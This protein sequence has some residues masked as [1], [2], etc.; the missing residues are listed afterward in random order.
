M[1]DEKKKLTS[2]FIYYFFPTSDEAKKI[3]V[4]IRGPKNIVSVALARKKLF[5]TCPTRHPAK[6]PIAIKV[7]ERCILG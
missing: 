6:R 2:N 3:L 1:S 7:W 5:L 4:G